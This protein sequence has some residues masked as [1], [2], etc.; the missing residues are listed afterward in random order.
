MLDFSL[1]R[2][3]STTL[4][5]LAQGITVQDLH[6]L[7]DEMIREERAIVADATD[8]DVVFLPVDPDASDSFAANAAEVNVAWTLAH[9]IV[10]VTASA[11]EA[12]AQASQLARGVPVSGRNRY[13]TPWESVT[14]IAQVRERLEESRRMRH[15]ML[16]SWPNA[17]HLEL[18]YQA[19]YPGAKPVNAPGRFLGGLLHEDGHLEQLREIVRQ[20]HASHGSAG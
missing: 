3:G 14:S 8:D 5:E 17:P 4:M 16:E 6:A 19:G 11:E 7:T 20:A 1:I 10:H 2:S 13:E 18:L 9:V 15:A 12:A